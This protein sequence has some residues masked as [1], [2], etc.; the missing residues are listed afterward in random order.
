MPSAPKDAVTGLIRRYDQLKGERDSQWRSTWQ[1]ISNMFLPQ[2]SDIQTQK[3]AGNISGWTG[4]IYDTTGI[5]AAE[6]L[7]TGQYNWLTPPNQPWAEFTSPEELKNN[8]DEGDGAMDQDAKDFWARATDRTRMELARSNF[9]GVAAQHYLGKAVFATDLVICEESKKNGLLFRHYKIGTYCIEEDDE[10]IVDTAFIEFEWTFRQIEQFF[11]K[12][13]DNIPEKLRAAAAEGKEGYKRKFQLLHCIYPRKESERNPK[14]KDGSN[15][16]IASVYLSLEF[17]QGEPIRE[18]GFDE[19]PILCSRFDKWGG[20]SV[21]GYGPAYLMLT[22]ARQLNFVQQNL[23]AVAELHAYPRVLIPDNLAGDVDLR[24]GGATTFDTSNPNGMPSEWGTVSEYKLGLEMQEQRRNAL[25]E[26]FK[27]KAFNLLNSEPLLDKKMTAYE[28][29]Q[30]QAEQLGSFTP[31]FGRSITEFLNPLMQRV[32]GILYRAGKFGKAPDSLLVDTGNGT[33]GLAMPQVIISN[34]L[35][36]ALRALKNRSTEETF[37]FILA[38]QL[39]EMKPEI[40]DNFDL[41]KV[42]REYAENAGMPPDQMRSM[43]GQKGVMGIRT[44][45]AQMQQA[46]MKAQQLE[47]LSGAGKNLGGAPDWINSQAKEAFDRGATAA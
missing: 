33:R 11:S 18:G 20:T 38:N 9:Y 24:A 10:G 46:Q 2:D 45:R 37:Q 27:T 47:Q 15:K 26:A 23:D 29:S 3:Y 32:F 40:M 12:T 42:I 36:D 14:R 34:R 30:R 4:E 17:N 44:A 5:E 31:S 25:R 22:V 41:D 1:L 21:W 13:G 28:I 35:T 16:P 39:M 43:K 19:S 7:K 8:E 6:T